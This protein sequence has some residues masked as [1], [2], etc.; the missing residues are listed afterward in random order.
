MEEVRGFDESRREGYRA[1]VEAPGRFASIPPHPAVPDRD[2]M[3]AKIEA[4]V[5]SLNET[6]WSYQPWPIWFPE[7]AFQ[8][9]EPD[10]SDSPPPWYLYQYNPPLASTA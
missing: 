4:K 6:S 3:T 7:F 2:I 5:A 10:G 8:P 1:G 9:L